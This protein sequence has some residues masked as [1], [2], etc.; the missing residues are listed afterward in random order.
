MTQ[1]EK[2]ILERIRKEPMISQQALADEL[3][4]ARA[5]V[6]VHITNLMKKG[7]IRGKGYVLAEPDQAV[8]IGGANLDI[9]GFPGGV[10]R[11][12]VS[13][14]GTVK[15]ACGGVARNVAENLARLGQPVSLFTVV[16]NDEA[17]ERIRESASRV[18][19]GMDSVG[20][21]TRFPTSVYMAIQ[22]QSGEMAWAVS[23]MD[24]MEELTA[25]YLRE[26]KPILDAARTIVV[27]GNLSEA[28]LDY[29]LTHSGDV[30]VWYDPVSVE[31]AGRIGEHIGKLF[32]VK[33][34]RV[35]AETLSGIPADSRDG[36][37]KNWRWFMDQGIQE[38]W[39]SLGSE[40]LFFGTPESA[41]FARIDIEQIQNA[42]GAGDAL[43][44]GA[45]H[46]FLEGLDAEERVAYAL[47]AAA[48]ACTSDETIAPDFSGATVKQK[49]NEVTIYEKLS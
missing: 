46:G 2:E 17:G 24:I 18:G 6:A 14:P 30:P 34:N 32:A 35:E 33:P 26:R 31:K 20:V 40:G 28:A 3:G 9:Y 48:V 39:M 47:A 23:Q 11:P 8:V 37:L 44:A 15:T 12:G 38:L 45:L 36:V 25:A 5:S 43:L 16:G 41:L 29:L 4:I 21:S 27:D 1:R 19:I 7:L 49:M 10:L 13:N 42:N 22:E